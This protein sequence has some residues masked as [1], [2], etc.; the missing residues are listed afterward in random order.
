MTCGDPCHLGGGGI[1]SKPAWGPEETINVRGKAPRLGGGGSSL[2]GWPKPF[3]DT[4]PGGGYG[5]APGGPKKPSPKEQACA[6]CSTDFVQC[7]NTTVTFSNELQQ[8]YEK[9]YTEQCWMS[10]ERNYKT[11]ARGGKQIGDLAAGKTRISGFQPADWNWHWEGPVYDDP[12]TGERKMDLQGP[13]AYIAG[14]AFDSCKQSYRMDL[15]ASEF[16]DTANLEID[17][18]VFTFKAGGGKEVTIKYG[19]EKGWYGAVNGE[20]EGLRNLCKAQRDACFKAYCL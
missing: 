20:V 10:G 13:E 9:R 17:A 15:P 12:V 16:K 3:R 14:P 5:W 7:L 2:G 8:H 4:I 1:G 6:K 18:K 19:A 11:I